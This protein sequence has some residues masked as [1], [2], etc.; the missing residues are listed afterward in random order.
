MP[1]STQPF[2][3]FL[4]LIQ[5]GDL[6][7]LTTYVTERRR[8]AVFFPLAPPTKPPT[9]D[10]IAQRS[11]FKAAIDAWNALP[12]ADK[13]NWER[14]AKRLSLG[15]TGFN[16]FTHFHLKPDPIAVDTLRRQSKIALKLEP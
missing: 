3:T 16:A 8:R 6:A 7:G 12:P 4:G 10:Q 9:A 11:A 15:L 5:S 1:K 13:S 2:Y 14:A